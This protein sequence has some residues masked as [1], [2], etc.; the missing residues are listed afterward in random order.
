MTV[1]R[2]EL[3][4]RSDPEALRRI[5]TVCRR[6]NCRIVTLSF[7]ASDA[8]SADRL[9]LALTGDAAQTARADRW[10]T[11][12]VDVLAIR[13]LVGTGDEGEAVDHCLAS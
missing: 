5:L 4:V 1:R 11:N 9:I 7:E 2:F 6:R 12:V 3:D 13:R 8:T 10:L